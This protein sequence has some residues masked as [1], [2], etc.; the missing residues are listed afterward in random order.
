MSAGKTSATL[1]FGKNGEVSFGEIG[2]TEALLRAGV[3]QCNGK[4]VFET[5]SKWLKKKKVKLE[6]RPLF[7]GANVR[8]LV[9][10]NENLAITK[11]AVVRLDAFDIDV[12][13]V[14]LSAYPVQ[15]KG[16]SRPVTLERD[17]IAEETLHLKGISI[18]LSCFALPVRPIVAC[19]DYSLEGL[20]FS[21]PIIYDNMLVGGSRCSHCC[22]K[23]YMVATRAVSCSLIYFLFPMNEV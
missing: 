2:T 8:C 11:Q 13:T 22:G 10:T 16:Q 18:H 20:E 6:G 7:K 21:I 19:T 3:K 23:A 9:K 17:I 1:T 5:I 14:T 15:G 12:G 4:V